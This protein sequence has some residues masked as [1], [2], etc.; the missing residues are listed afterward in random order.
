MTLPDRLRRRAML[1]GAAGA[2]LGGLAACKS[3]DEARGSGILDGTI[4]G[5][6]E[7]YD[8]ADRISVDD[9]QARLLNG[10]RID[11][12]R[13]DGIVSV[14]NVWGSWCGPCRA[15][16]PTLRA[17]ANAYRGRGV[18]FLGLN[19]RDN[20]AAAQAFERR[21]S[22]PYRSVHPDDAAEVSLAFGG[23]LTTT[24]V[25]TTVVVDQQRGVSS[26]VV[27]EVS[28]PTLRALVESALAT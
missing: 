26:R 17:V 28:R 1:L 24:A 14:V 16:A 11:A 3:D 20:P 23:K 25:P 19:V 12:S 8:P 5:V 22:M 21:F 6:V 10:R 18:R 7:E 9:F 4:D 2:G 13:L 27:G 15:E